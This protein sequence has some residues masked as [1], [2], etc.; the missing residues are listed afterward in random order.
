MKFLSTALET[1][2]LPTDIFGLKYLPHITSGATDEDDHIQRLMDTWNPPEHFTKLNQD[3]LREALEATNASV[4]LEIGVDRPYQAGQPS[5]TKILVG[6]KR[7][8]AT[9]IG[10]DRDQ[11]NI[12]GENVHFIQG[13]SSNHKLVWDVMDT[14]Q[15]EKIDLLFIDG[16]HSVN[17]IV[18]DWQYTQRLSD[19]GAVVMH[20]TNIHPGPTLLFEAIDGALF[21]KQKYGEI[22]SDWG[23]SVCRRK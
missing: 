18:R 14:L 1:E 5:S 11:K 7:P 12:S 21:D 10:V 23:I 13:D 6:Y 17:Q 19:G 8:M 16:L 20:D 15:L 9:Y 22:Q 3:E 2:K 4:I